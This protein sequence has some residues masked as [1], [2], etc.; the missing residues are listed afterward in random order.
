M[1]LG[2]RAAANQSGRRAGL[3][4]APGAPSDP[5][6]NPTQCRK[7]LIGPS[8]HPPLYGTP[9]NLPLFTTGRRRDALAGA[10]DG[11][12]TH[13]KNQRKIIRATDED[14]PVRPSR[15]TPSQ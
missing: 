11:H 1:F 7:H 15:E 4:V 2:A 6:R 5:W 10:S 13:P 12:Y 14:V 3:S 8:P 9:Q